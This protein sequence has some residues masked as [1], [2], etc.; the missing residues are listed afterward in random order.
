MKNKK[1]SK[2]KIKEK[3]EKV[4]DLFVNLV[5]EQGNQNIMQQKMVS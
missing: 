5:M 1:C 3:K 4:S 2:C